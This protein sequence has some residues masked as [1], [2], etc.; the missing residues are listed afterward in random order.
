MNPGDV[1]DGMGLKM[2][3]PQVSQIMLRQDGEGTFRAMCF[4]DLPHEFDVFGVM[5]EADAVGECSVVQR[6]MEHIATC[7][8]KNRKPESTTVLQNNQT[9]GIFLFKVRWAA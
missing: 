9:P 4:E 7:S 8:L 3:D 6:C 5:A 1:I 2:K